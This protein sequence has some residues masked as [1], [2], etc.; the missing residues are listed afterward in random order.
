MKQITIVKR[1]GSKVPLDLGKWQAQISKVCDGI[2]DVSRS[3]IEMRAH[4]QFY[5]G[6]STREIDETTLRAIVNLIDEDS[7]PE[8][9]NTNYQFVA[10]RQRLSMLRKDVYGQYTP[11]RLFER[12]ADTVAAGFYTDE[13]LAWYTE[14]EWDTIESFIDYTRDEDLPFAAIEQLVDKYLVRN[15][16][17]GTPYE[18]PQVRYIVA[19]ATAFHAE[20]ENRL[21]KVKTFYDCASKG[22]FT[23]ATPVLAGLGTPTKQF[24]SCVLISTGDSIKSIFAS[25]EVMAEYAAKRAGIGFDVSRIRGIGAAIRGGELKHTGMLPFLKKWFGD[26][27]SVSQNGIRNA[28]C[29]VNYPIWHW[30]FEDLIVLKNNQGTEETRVRQMDYSVTTAKLFWRRFVDGGNI[31]LFDPADQPELAALFYQDIDAFEVA[32]EKFEKSKTGRKKVIPA[33]E[34]F[35]AILKERTDTG[36]IYLTFIDN[37]QKQGP[38][39]TAITPI[40]MSNLCLT[41]DT[42]IDVKDP[43]SGHEFKATLECLVDMFAWGDK[44]PYPNGLLIKSFD[45]VLNSVVWSELSAAAETG[46]DENLVTIRIDQTTIRCTEDHEIFTKRGYI[47]ADDLA[48]SDMFMSADGEWCTGVVWKESVPETSVFDLTVPATSNFFANGIL[49]H[50]CK[51]ILQYT[52]PF[53]RVDDPAGRIA[54]CT[55]GSIHLSRFSKPEQ[56][57]SACKILVRALSNLLGYQDYMSIHSKLHTEEFEPLGVGI[58]GLAHWMAKRKYKYGQPEALQELR[59]WMEHFYFYLAETSAELA[60][61]K[62]PA[63]R[64]KDTHWADG[65]FCW[66]RRAT[67][68]NELADFTPK[69]DWE[70]LR[71][72]IKN[73]G[74]RNITLSAQAPVESSSVAISSTNGMEMPM[75]LVSVK[76]SK[77]GSLVQVVPEYNKLKKHYQLMW[78]QDDCLDYLK[79]AAVLGVFMDQSLSTNTFYN[80]AKFADRHVPQTLIAKNILLAQRYGLKTLYYSLVNKQGAKIESTGEQHTP[81]VV[82]EEECEACKL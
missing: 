31:T 32:Y 34:L 16:V 44:G 6:M 71:T 75:S 53:E 29:T 51:E 19:A 1:D 12:V 15:R 10:G 37:V 57:K 49:V 17:T 13:L 45:H 47:R 70:P 20:K 26:L 73:T 14:A 58:T 4:P 18:T 76:E 60:E 21:E 65:T 66:E 39:K 11:T 35:K 23:L 64:W 69:L 48:E 78:E 24:S 5:D 68:V 80:P 41:G 30:Q 8:E 81:V 28:S 50:N 7:N 74:V 36:R 33:D 59:D 43:A 62:G 79:T 61:E 40:T 77:G 42:L 52:V 67:A 38:F 82:E 27:R 63:T 55:L 56:M 3:M 54:L 72:R 2:Q 9:C 22:M 46:R 25:G